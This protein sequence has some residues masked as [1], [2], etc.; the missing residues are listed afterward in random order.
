[1][2]TVDANHSSVKRTFVG[3]TDCDQDEQMCT[4]QKGQSST[5]EEKQDRA[6]NTNCA[7]IGGQRRSLM[8][9]LEGLRG[10]SVLGV[11]GRSLPGQGI[12]RAESLLQGL[13]VQIREAPRSLGRS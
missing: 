11:W 2:T 8:V 1:M 12:A 6:Q 4:C 9:T 10:L 13:F 3:E 5:E 7:L